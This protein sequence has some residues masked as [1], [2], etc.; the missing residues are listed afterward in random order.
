M[1]ASS[2]GRLV[3]RHTSQSSTSVIPNVCTSHL[4][5]AGATLPSPCRIPMEGPL[6]SAFPV[7]EKLYIL[8][9]I[10][11]E[12]WAWVDGMSCSQNDC[13]KAQEI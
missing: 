12:N 5:R 1:L 6:G 8:R 10:N 4:P 3:L 9:Q 2:A 7:F 13:F 11:P